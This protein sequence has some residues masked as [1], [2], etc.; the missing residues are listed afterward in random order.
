MIEKLL[1]NWLDN[2]SERSYQPVFVQILSGQGYRVVHS[3]RHTALEY[4]KDVLAVAP[5]GEGCAFQLKG[6]PGG[7][8]G[9][10]EFRTD[11]QPQ[12]IQLMSQPVVFPGF[13]SK[14]HKAFLVSNGYFEEEVQR[15]VDDLN[16]GSY[17]SKVSLITRGDLLQWSRELGVSLWPAELEDSRLLLELFLSSPTDLFP[18]SKLST[19]ISK[20]LALGIDEKVGSKAEFLRRVTSAAL[21]TGIVT[22]GFAE[23]TNHFAVACAWALFSVSIL[24]AAEKHEI[25]P[26]GAAHEALLLAEA[27]AADALAELWSEVNERR[28]L[29]EGNAFADPEVYGWRYTTLLGALTCLALFDDARHVLSDEDSNALRR[30]LMRHHE[31]VDLWGEGALGCIV[32]WLIWLRKHD[33]TLRSDLEIANLAEVVV[34]RNQSRSPSPLAS[35]YYSF[36]QVARFNLRLGKLRERTLLEGETFA[37][38]SFTA[39][40]LVHL[41]VRTNLKQRCKHIWSD[42]TR[43]S[44]RT[45]VP[46]HSWEYCCLRVALGVSQTKLYPYTYNW[47]DLKREALS[48]EKLEVPVELATRPW[49][50]AL[51]WQVAPHRCTTPAT[52]ALADAVLPEWG[53]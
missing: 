1:E 10:S 29:V 27:A 17:P 26:D 28:H 44:H 41:M 46:D 19:L 20:V 7:K 42:F 4:G 49:L 3:T 23:T 14:P 15:A 9:L 47:D 39:E 48:S 31:N 45:C 25:S 21:L 24:A 18:A 30:W 5:T 8:L 35:P 36:E 6:Q 38:S 11:I 13:P 32:P 12:L 33:A 34:A 16:R 50:L 37:G 2:A 40:L 53:T 22:A 43:L 51:W 52:H